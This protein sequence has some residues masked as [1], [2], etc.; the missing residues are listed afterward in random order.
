MVMDQATADIG[1][2]RDVGD[3]GARQP[4]LQ[5]DAPGGVQQFGPALISLI[6]PATPGA[7]RTA[8]AAKTTA[9]IAAI[10]AVDTT[11]PLTVDWSTNQ[12]R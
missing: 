10:R 3:T 11:L 6:G 4:S 7:L 5:H 1:G 12:S 9:A 2:L 8:H